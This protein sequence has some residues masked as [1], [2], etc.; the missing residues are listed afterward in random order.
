MRSAGIVI[1]KPIL[2]VLLSSLL[3]LAAP[4]TLIAP[5]LAL[6]APTFTVNSAADV[7]A[8]GDLTNG[9]CQTASGNNV[10]T[11][12]AAIMKANHFLGGGVTINIP[13]GTYTLTTP[14]SG[15]D[16]EII[17]NLNITSSMS[18]IGAG[19]A[20]TI[21]DGNGSATNDN[22]IFVD[23]GVS[24]TI[25]NVTIQNG[26]PV[27]L[28]GG[29]GI[30]TYG[31]LTLTNSTVSGNNAGSSSS[32]GG[33][34]NSGNLTLTNS[35]VSGNNAGFGG[36]GIW[37]DNGTGTVDVINSTVSGNSASNN[38]GG[39]AN[40]HGTVNVINSTI[41]GNNATTS[42]GGIWNNGTVNVINST[43]SGNNSATD[44]GGIMN[45]GTSNLFNATTTN[46]QADS[47]FN[48]SGRGGG[49]FNS[50]GTVNFIDSIIALNSET[51]KVVSLWFPV[52]G[53]CV[54]T[55]TSL[56]FSILNSYDTSQCTV[57]G[58]FTLADPK[59]GLLQNNGGATQTH[60]LLAGS[61]A[62]DAGDNNP[63]GCKD[64]LGATLTTDQRGA[65]RPV[66]G[67][68]E[69]RCDI[70]AYE[71][72]AKI[73]QAIAFSPLANKTFG[74]PSFGVSAIASSGLA[75]TFTAAGQ[76]NVSGNIV[77]LTGAGSCTVTAHQAGNSTYNAAPDVPQSFTIAKSNQ[78]ITF[79]PLANKTSGDPSFSVSATA[80]SGLAVTFTAAGQC[81]VSGVTVT[82]TGA[83]SCTVT[84]H[85]AGNSNTNPAPDVPQSFT[86]SASGSKLYLPLIVR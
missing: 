50:G 64:K 78:T 63:G 86:I 74:D 15:S 39:I 51:A 3:L 41:S 26:R 83:G 37:N 80:S 49:I 34:N 44:G 52:Y 69:L 33:I 12:R 11:L 62:I 45:V 4:A 8:G 9:V 55:I 76:C 14:K 2:T 75:V 58:S 24:V 23:F 71:Y 84:A 16:D 57:N 18:I 6:A 31:N 29:G 66:N 28:G 70:G 42:G 72:L 43:I 17:G 60:A 27:S 47:D 59:I 21:I 25:S 68:S 20:S 67:G 5:Q 65:T 46:N 38:G 19:A 1:P 79:G 22:V 73:P 30:F 56:G 82:L 54:G 13:S 53:D 48:G 32:G 81:S 77:T 10:C 36:G 35:T 40:D 7:V 61:P 85:Q